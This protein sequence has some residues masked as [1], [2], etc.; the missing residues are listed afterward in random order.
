MCNNDTLKI[1]EPVC[2]SVEDINLYVKDI[3]IE[4]WVIQEKVDFNSYSGNPT[5]SI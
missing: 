1:N 5:F 2:A 3:S 4:T